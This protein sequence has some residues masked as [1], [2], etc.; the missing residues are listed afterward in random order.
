MSCTV[1]NPAA[2]ASVGM[3][4]NALLICWMRCG[5]LRQYSSF[6][7]GAAVR[8]QVARKISR[9]SANVLERRNPEANG[10]GAPRMP[11]VVRGPRLPYVS[12]VF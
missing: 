6:D 12:L 11:V 7:P 10:A 5:F 8:T 2:L 9:A 1:L 3:P 4:K